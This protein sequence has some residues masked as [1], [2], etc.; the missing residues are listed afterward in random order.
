[1]HILSLIRSLIELR[2]VWFSSFCVPFFFDC[3][4]FFSHFWLLIHY[5]GFVCVRVV[6]Q[7]RYYAVEFEFC[8]ARFAF[9]VYDKFLRSL[10]WCGHANWTDSLIHSFRNDTKIRG[11]HTEWAYFCPCSMNYYSSTPIEITENWI[12]VALKCI[13]LEMAIDTHQNWRIIAIV[14]HYIWLFRSI[15]KTKLIV[16]REFSLLLFCVSGMESFLHFL[17]LRTL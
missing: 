15:R 5:Y 11:A 12:G 6:D 1:M 7:E 2:L 10:W 3:G 13:T 9:F 17:N 14:C 4:F 8:F 16:W